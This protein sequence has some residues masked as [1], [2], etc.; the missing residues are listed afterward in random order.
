MP[1]IIEFNQSFD[2]SCL[3][4]KVQ[5]FKHSRLIQMFKLGR[6]Q[7]LVPNVSA[8]EHYESRTLIQIDII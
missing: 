1:A 6:T 2:R 4:Q 3:D 7:H 5:I 8:V